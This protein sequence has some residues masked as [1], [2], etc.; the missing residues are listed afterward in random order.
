MVT[1][2]RSVQESRESFLVASPYTRLK[3]TECFQGWMDVYSSPSQQSSEA[4]S[5]RNC[6]FSAQFSGPEEPEAQRSRTAHP[7]SEATSTGAG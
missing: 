4:P 1:E 5:F 3:L 7:G 6:C 2:E